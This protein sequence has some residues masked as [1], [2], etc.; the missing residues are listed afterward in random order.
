MGRKN[1]RG[2][3]HQ[4]PNC[5]VSLLE[6]A[7]ITV[8]LQGDYKDC[9]EIAKTAVFLQG[10]CSFCREIVKIAVF[11]QGDCKNCCL[12]AGRLAGWTPGMQRET[13]RGPEPTP[14]SWWRWG[15]ECQPL[16]CPTS[17]WFSLT[18]MKRWG[19]RRLSA[20]HL[21]VSI[22][23]GAP[24]MLVSV[25]TKVQSHNCPSNVS[26]VTLSPVAASG[27]LLSLKVFEGLGKI[28]WHIFEPLKP[29]RSLK[30]ELLNR[31]LKVYEFWPLLL[32]WKARI[33]SWLRKWT[34]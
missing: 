20:C 14:S 6:I 25:Q 13:P 22:E 16:P 7:N 3:V 27:L 29:F 1:C 21:V 34:S 28:I 2:E 26:T 18:W 12:F 19:R 24:W 9:R 17:A 11:L 30:N 10:D 4:R 32:Y 23:S 33:I 8:F 5:T 15:R 31:S